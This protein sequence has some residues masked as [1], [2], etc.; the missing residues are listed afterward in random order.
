MKENDA[1]EANDRRCFPSLERLL[2]SKNDDDE[3]NVKKVNADDGSYVY[4]LFDDRTGRLLYGCE[5]DCEGDLMYQGYYSREGKREGKKC[6]A[7]FAGDVV[8]YG[9]Y[10]NGLPEGSCVYVYP[11]QNEIRET[12]CSRGTRTKENDDDR[13]D[14]E[15]DGGFENE[16]RVCAKGL[17]DVLCNND[18]I[19]GDFCEGKIDFEEGVRSAI[20]GASVSGRARP[21]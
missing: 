14:E 6:L 2:R 3:D 7:F 8:I 11:N 12:L 20:A 16:Q 5:Y 18:Y 17:W 9:E 15:D 4:G 13:D 21:D 19:L 1:A 10:R